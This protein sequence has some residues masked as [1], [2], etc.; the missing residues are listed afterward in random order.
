MGQ[1]ISAKTIAA[2][3]KKA[4]ALEAEMW[5]KVPYEPFPFEDQMVA[6]YDRV[7]PLRNPIYSKWLDS[8]KELRKQHERL[9]RIKKSLLPVHSAF[10][11][12]SREDV[13]QWSWALH[14]S[15]EYREVMTKLHS[16]YVAEL[17]PRY[18]L[19]ILGLMGIAL[20][21]FAEDIDEA[22]AD[23]EYMLVT[24][25]KEVMAA[26]LIEF[27]KVY[28]RIEERTRDYDHSHEKWIKLYD[29]ATIEYLSLSWGRQVTEEEALTVRKKYGQLTKDRI[30]GKPVSE[31][32]AALYL[33]DKMERYPGRP[34][35]FSLYEPGKRL[36]RY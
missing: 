4:E 19:N 31:S 2:L 32:E 23:Y 8:D 34:I 36:S 10:L 26:S 27:R 33:R 7:W 16:R 18:D 9:E 6:F 22:L 11:P 28:V 12:Y 14:R 13:R 29:Q 17:I 21:V 25:T 30:S 3:A 5:A 35:D 1:R 24:T 15:D 20:D